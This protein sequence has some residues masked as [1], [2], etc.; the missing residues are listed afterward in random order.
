M[1]ARG[2]LHQ[3]L[4]ARLLGATPRAQVDPLGQQQRFDQVGRL[5]R[6]RHEPRPD[7]G[8]ERRHEPKVEAVAAELRLVELALDDLVEHGRQPLAIVGMAQ[9]EDLHALD[10]RRLAA[11]HPRERRVRA[12][13]HPLAVEQGLADR[14]RLERRPQK[15]LRALQRAPVLLELG[16][17][18]DLGPQQIGVE[19]LEHVVDGPDAVTAQDVADVVVGSGQEDDRHIAR[20]RPALDQ[21]RGLNP[22]EVGHPDVEQDQRDVVLEQQPQ[23]LVSGT[24]REQRVAER[25]QH[26]VERVQVLLTV[27]DDQDR[28]D[29]DRSQIARCLHARDP[30]GHRL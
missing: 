29:A 19:R 28:Q 6:R 2:V 24:R 20:A 23:R 30:R 13:D 14:R 7:L 1:G 22:V 8:A 21:L 5:N 10:L 12:H 11:D 15:R 17:H 9:V 26:A 4:G 25:R 3:Q 18:R 16:E 27:V